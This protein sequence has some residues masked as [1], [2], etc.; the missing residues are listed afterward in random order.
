MLDA[1]QQQLELQQQQV[2]ARQQES[3]VRISQADERAADLRRRLTERDELLEIARRE[4]EELRNRVEQQAEAL[5]AQE[6]RRGIWESMLRD[7]LDPNADDPAA[8]LVET[9][10]PAPLAPPTRTASS[11][12]S[13]TITVSDNVIRFEP[14]VEELPV[15]QLVSDLSRAADPKAEA[16]LLRRV[17][18]AQARVAELES[19]LRAAEEQINAL[20]AALRQARGGGP[21]LET[22]GSAAVPDLDVAANHLLNEELLA[23]GPARFLAQIR[24]D[25]EILH[26]LTRRTTIGRAPDNDIRID[27]NFV[28]RYH[29]AVMAGPHQTVIEDLGST[30]GLVING[31]RVVRHSLRD[32]DVIRIGKSRFRFLTRSR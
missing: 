18:D 26:R 25:T 17:P 27:A 14:R 22:A 13:P 6:G 15:D 20:E 7:A 3:L 8:T 28:S 2:E 30:N 10:P 23:E 9:P 24:G 4:L 29:A 21:V 32:G 31:R 5:R 19:D 1:V 12:E 11:A 16:D